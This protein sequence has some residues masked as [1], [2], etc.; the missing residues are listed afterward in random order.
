[1]FKRLLVVLLCACMLVSTS[2]CVT[3]KADGPIHVGIITGMKDLSIDHYMA[4][5]A[6]IQKYG[7]V[8]SGGIIKHVSLKDEE[9]G[10]PD[11]VAENIIKLIEDPNL[12]IIVMAYGFEGTADGFNKVKEKSPDVLC[13][14]VD[15]MDDSE[16][17]EYSADLIV[18]AD[19]TNTGYMIPWIAKNLGAKNF[20][21]ISF[22]RHLA[23]EN[24]ARRRVI[25]KAACERQKIHYYDKYAPD[26]LEAKSDQQVLD[27][28]AQKMPEWVEEYGK[29]TAFFCTNNLHTDEVVKQVAK[30]GA[31]FV[32]QDLPSPTMGYQN[33]FNIDVTGIE[34]D[35]KSL[36]D[37]VEKAVGKTPGNKRMGTW[38]YSYD[39][40]TTSS[41][42]E[43]GLK[44]KEMSEFYKTD[45]NLYIEALNQVSNVH[46]NVFFSYNPLSRTPKEN[47]VE[48]YQDTY[49]LNK[50]P[51]DMS[52]VVIPNLFD[53]C[54]DFID[55]HNESTDPVDILA[56][57]E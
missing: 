54:E 17:I 19:T 21:H 20:I 38:A 51:V 7:A 4:V 35:Y 2:A 42:V 55:E 44:M 40:A 31:I 15:S 30:L 22:E 52:R 8:E 45:I 14:V 53:L 36:L 23:L 27:Y 37:A 11:V 26:P 49:I 29:D 25:M 18:D 34:G 47:R 5:Q 6:L 39:N 50:G 16:S 12:Q 13:F 1:M 33:A 56:H 28:L 46:W 3:K 24:V 48:I 41:L 57:M 10:N 32:Q 43:Y 9:W